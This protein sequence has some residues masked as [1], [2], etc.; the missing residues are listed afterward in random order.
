MSYNSPADR[1]PVDDPAE[2]RL[3]P[4]AAP[5]GVRRP[6]VAGHLHHATA[7]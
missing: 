1:P 4:A 7:S 3:A 5:G 6:G 2:L